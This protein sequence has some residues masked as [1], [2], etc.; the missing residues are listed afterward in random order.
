MEKKIECGIVYDLLPNY[1][2]HLTNEHSNA[3]VENHLTT[4]DELRLPSV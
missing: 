3:F 2:E 1:I 4:C